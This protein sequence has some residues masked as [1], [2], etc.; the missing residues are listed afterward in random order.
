[1]KDSQI[2]ENIFK[3][4][5]THADDKRATAQL[6]FGV[7]CDESKRFKLEVLTDA[8]MQAAKSNSKKPPRIRIASKNYDD[9][10]DNYDGN[11]DQLM[12]DDSNV[13]KI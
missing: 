13:R 10:D 2:S 7:V 11:G 3:F 12:N 4:K 5:Y 6:I 9:S 1:M 8:V